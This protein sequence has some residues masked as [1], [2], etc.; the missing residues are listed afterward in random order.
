MRTMKVYIIMML[1]AVVGNTFA[2][3]LRVEAFSIVPGETKAVSVELNN[4][5]HAYTLLEFILTLPEG[6]SIAK[7]EDNKWLATPNA[8]R[9]TSS[10]SLN[11]E[12]RED[13]SYKFL[14]YSG[15]NK[16]LNGT[17]GELFFL[18]LVAADD[19]V[20]GTYQGSFTE[21]LFVDTEEWEYDPADV[22]FEVKIGVA[23]DGDVNGDNQVSIA[24][25]T[26]LVNIILG[27]DNTMPYLYDHDAANVNGDNTVSIA[28][29]TALVNIIL[30]KQ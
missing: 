10:H 5:A 2:D 17:S 9:F 1:L 12:E 23:V 15:R 16:A 28:D 21:Q 4:P 18:T 14:I 22:N 29:V 6:V 20:R 8:S 30:G 7:D 11:I 25:V 19:A 24:D 27:K 3:E 13:G 26:A